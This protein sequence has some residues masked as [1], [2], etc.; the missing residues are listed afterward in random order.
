MPPNPTVHPWLPRLAV[1]ACAALLAAVLGC[2]PLAGRP[3][4]SRLADS[5]YWFLRSQY[6]E[7]RRR[8]DSAVENLDKALAASG[9]SAFLR[10]E[11]ARLQ[12]RVGRPEAAAAHVDRAIELDPSSVEA[13]VFAAW[14]AT[15]TGQ[16]ELAEKRYLEALEIDPTHEEAL[17]HLGALYAESGRLPEASDAF[18][19]LGASAPTSFLPDYYMALLAQ[20]E[21]DARAAVTHLN[22]ALGKNPEFVAA[23]N[24]LAM[25][26]EALGRLRDA[27]RTYGRVLKLRPEAMLPRARLARIYLKTGRR[28][29]AAAMLREVDAPAGGMRTGLMIA[30]AYIEE[31]MLAEAG[32]ELETLL[33]E[34]PQDDQALYLLASVKTD[35][36]DRAGAM[37]LLRRITPV[38]RQYVDSRLLLCGLLVD[39][40]RRGEALAVIVEARE[41]SG[42]SP[43]LALAHGTLLEEAGRWAEAKGIYVAWLKKYSEVAEVRFRLGYVED[44]LGDLPACIS[45]MR[46]AVE[47]DP[48]HAEALNYMAYTWAERRE[49]LDEALTMA[50]RAS[51]IKPD[52]GYILDTVAWIYYAMG[53]LQRSLPL[54]ERAAALSGGDPVILEHLGD[55]LKALGRNEEAR[56]A[57]NQA[58]EKGHESP[59]AINDKLESIDN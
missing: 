38:M 27:E 3:G 34:H 20:R 39:D 32:G 4:D 22:R 58:V 53:D 43:Q 50:L 47:L 7:L 55:A 57:Y 30:L 2:A 40:G 5:Y 35:L 9:D 15:T 8:D 33:A 1:L 41:Q 18:R 42:G 26:Y 52:N 31:G 49:N 48:D 29:Q 13:R 6:D 10:L 14:L 17:S 21:G 51:N 59:G 28:P 36:G 46:K 56:R 25:C 24:E 44:K 16:M 23:L 19:R 11:A 54:L 37:E 12:V 45:E